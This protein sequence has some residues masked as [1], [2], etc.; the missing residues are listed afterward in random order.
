MVN[1]KTEGLPNREF[2]FFCEFQVAFELQKRG[3]QV[4]QPLIDR[5]I[6]LI[7]FKNGDYITI[8]VKSSRVENISTS[9]KGEYESYGLTMKPKDL[10]HDV[11][12]FFVWM[13][14][15]KE[16]KFHYFILN[17]KD[18]IDVRFHL[19]P[20]HSTTHRKYPSLLMRGEWRWGTDRLHPH[21]YFQSNKW[22]V[23]GI[24][25]NGYKNGWDKL[26]VKD[27]NTSYNVI[28]FEATEIKEKWRNVS[29][30]VLNERQKNN[31]EAIS[32]IKKYP[33][34]YKSSKK[35]LNETIDEEEGI[36][37]AHLIRLTEE[38][39]NRIFQKTAENW[40]VFLP[41]ES[42]DHVLL[43]RPVCA[44]CGKYWNT[45]RKECF[46]CKTKYFRI[47][48]CENEN[49]NRP[50][51]EN[52]KPT[53]KCEKCGGSLIKKCINCGEIEKERKRVFVPITFCW[54]CGTR[55]NKFEFERIF[56]GRK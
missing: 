48:V 2:S 36:M 23:E 38:E 39:A 40:E 34:V 7:A 30:E 13:F 14:I 29:D 43:F 28:S 31:E 50:Y 33:E 24:E 35:L 5:Y 16:N 3:W 8:Q 49:C 55:E 20:E 42:T 32:K 15:D 54:Y 27:K 17:V 9:S 18:F 11:R 56:I 53:Q 41:L 21:H 45:S 26:N 44:K 51:P 22:E 25:L 37:D 52:V 1:I 4:Y 6:D 46:Y 10:F 12:H 19:L 47:K